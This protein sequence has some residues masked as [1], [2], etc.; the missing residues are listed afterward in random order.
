MNENPIS[1]RLRRYSR[2]CITERLDPDF[3]DAVVEAAKMLDTS[4]PVAHWYWDK[5]GMDWGIGA[6]RCSAC[7]RMSPMWWNT[8]KGSPKHRSG[9]NYCPICGADM[10]EGEE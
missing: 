9:H 10:R 5:D 4:R 3:A 6:W 2:K 8:D 7:K 1:K